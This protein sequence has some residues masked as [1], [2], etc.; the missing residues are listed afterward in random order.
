[1]PGSTTDLRILSALLVAFLFTVPV[2][3]ASTTAAWEDGKL[4]FQEG[5]YTLALKHFEAARD[6]GVSGPAVHYNI[7]VA[8]Y[9]LRRYPDARRSFELIDRRYPEMQ[10]LAQYNLGL[11]AAKEGR[12][13]DAKRHF[14]NSYRLSGDSEKL[15]V[16]SATMWRRTQVVEEEP[17]NWLGMVS[18][19]VGFDDNVALR[20]ELGLPV[21]V[22][23][24]SPLLELAGTLRGPVAGS[25][26]FRLDGGAYI[27]RYLDLEE[28]NQSVFRLGG[29]YDWRSPDWFAQ[30]SAHAGYSTLDGDGFENTGSAGFKVGRYLTETSSFSIHYRYDDVSA[31]ESIFSGI[32]GSKQ[33]LDVRYRWYDED[34]SFSVAYRNASNDRNDPGVSPS[35]DRFIMHFRYMP[36]TGWGYEIGAD[37]RASEYDELIPVRKEDLT[38]LRFGVSR[39]VATDWHAFARLEVAE[40]DSNVDEFSYDRNQLAVGIRKFW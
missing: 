33:R 20:D 34:R 24:E 26:G 28:F 19:R 39:V 8:Q 7:A 32:D 29:L 18:A 27:V 37:F 25:N 38:T 23:A 1:M 22:T 3:A 31:V 15:R 17:S 40:N 14:L 4:A 10:S 9:R 36:E 21:G 35:R 30:V 6:S 12:N 2:N 11:V 13:R 5:D 16:L